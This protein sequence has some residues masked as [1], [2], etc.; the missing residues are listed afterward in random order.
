MKIVFMGTP[1]FAVPSLELLIKSGYNVA[2]VYTKTDKPKNRGMKVSY[3]PIKELAIQH[4]IEVV[5][6]VTLYDGSEAERL[7]NIKPDCIVVTAY[8]KLLPENVLRIP[9]Y[10]CVNVHASILPRYRGAGPIQ[11]AVLNGETE[12]G[13]TTML[14][15]KE[16]DA[17]D[18]LLTDKTEIGEYE[19]AG[20][21]HDRLAQIGAQLLIRTLEGLQSGSIRAAAQAHNQATYA[22]MLSKQDSPVDWSKTPD[23]IN[24]QVRGLN[25]WPVA[26]GMIGGES[27]KIYKVLKTEKTT[28]KQPG[29]VVG[30]SGNGIEIACG[31]GKVIVITQLQRPGGKIMSASDYLRGH[32]IEV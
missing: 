25:P 27:F 12:T 10:G 22:P 26:A 28:E 23:E 3:S 24:N 20:E 18:M 14:M 30:A 2:V 9:R 29:T 32:S 17:G 19:T 1:E 31:G 15:A 11:H 13:I 16:L 4:G 6:P 21:L 7:S 8:G 5:Q